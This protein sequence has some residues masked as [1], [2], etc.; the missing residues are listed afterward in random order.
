MNKKAILFDVDG[1]L[2]DAWDFII[3]AMQYSLS[4]HGYPEPS[5]KEIGKALGK[6]LVEF[7]QILMPTADPLKL[8]YTHQEF[9]KI[10]PHL[11]K[12]FPNT[13]KT[14][15]VLKT[16]G[17]FLAV[18]SNRMRESLLESLKLT[19]IHDYFDV[20]VS[21]DD[22]GNC[23]PHKDHLL[24]ALEHLQIKPENAYIVGDTE[25]DILAGKNAQVKTIGVTYGL[26]GK[27]IAE[28]KP[29]FIINDIEELLKICNC[30]NI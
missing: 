4:E 14:L 11:I 16:S 10:N 9:Q 5:K 12:L 30:A 15:K 2:L 17:F 3:G 29:D 23:K 26:E 20:I 18:V 13:V 7:Y 25:V 1:T 8:A 28:H 6:S 21:A 27:K 19:G 22:V 24:V